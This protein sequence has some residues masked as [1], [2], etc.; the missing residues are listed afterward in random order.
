[1]NN[2]ELNGQ[3]RSYYAFQFFRDFFLIGGV[4]IPFF[5]I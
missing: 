1:M 5:T 2:K 4:L 3:I